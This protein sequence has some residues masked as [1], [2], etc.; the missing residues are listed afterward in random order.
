MEILQVT[1]QVCNDETAR[2][3]MAVRQLNGMVDRVWA[4]I[5][6]G[7]VEALSSKPDDVVAGSTTQIHCLAGQYCSG[8]DSPGQEAGWFRQVPGNILQRKIPVDLFHLFS[9]V[10]G[11]SLVLPGR[12]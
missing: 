3:L 7:H 1:Q 2:H 6:A 10:H 11:D 5:D 8:L 9:E 12:V 4:E